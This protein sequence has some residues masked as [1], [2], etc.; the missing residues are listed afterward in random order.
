[1][2]VCYTL[3]KVRQTSVNAQQLLKQKVNGD[4]IGIN[5]L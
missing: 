5:P 4:G 1:M 3:A 2:D